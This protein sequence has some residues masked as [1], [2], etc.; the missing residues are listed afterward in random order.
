ML[1]TRAGSQTIYELHGHLREATCIHCFKVYPAQPLIAEFL[2]SDKIPTCPDC[3][4]ILKPNAILYGE[5]LPAQ[6]LNPG[7]A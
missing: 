3:G 2:E 4:H 6:A 5:Q 7:A 1:H